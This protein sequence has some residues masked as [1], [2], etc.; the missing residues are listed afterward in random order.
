MANP[1]YVALGTHFVASPGIDQVIFENIP[2]THKDLVLV[3]TGRTSANRAYEFC[4]VDL[5][6][7]GGTYFY[8]YWEVGGGQQAGANTN[9]TSAS[10]IGLTGSQAAAG[11]LGMMRYTIYDY[12]SSSVAKNIFVETMAVSYVNYRNSFTWNDTSPVTSVRFKLDQG[13]TLNGG[14]RV[15]LYGLGG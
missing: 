1:T 7:G 4:S 14:A 15:T 9:G 8:Q 10:T 3:A 13:A 11:M 12:A 6:G 2:N 5:N